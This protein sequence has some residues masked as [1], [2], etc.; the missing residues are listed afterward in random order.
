MKRRKTNNNRSMVFE[1]V[2]EGNSF[3]KNLAGGGVRNFNFGRGGGGRRGVGGGG[4]HV[5]LK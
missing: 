3:R 5:I 4:G 2:S 1:I